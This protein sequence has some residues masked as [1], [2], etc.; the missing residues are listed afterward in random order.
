MVLFPIAVSHLP[1]AKTWLP[2]TVAILTCF[3]PSRSYDDCLAILR[4]LHPDAA[5]IFCLAIYGNR[6]R[7]R[8]ASD[9]HQTAMNHTASGIACLPI[10]Y[11]FL[12]GCS[13]TIYP[14]HS[15]HLTSFNFCRR[16]RGVSS[17]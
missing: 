4:Q 3:I 7:I 12:Y 1:P 15:Y 11:G 5:A 8:P 9:M 14:I 13:Q 2:L 16:L 6:K 10:P 17:T